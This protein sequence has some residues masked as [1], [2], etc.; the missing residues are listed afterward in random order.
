MKTRSLTLLMFIVITTLMLYGCSFFRGTG[1]VTTD[2]NSICSNYS[3]SDKS[4]LPVALIHDMINGYRGNQLQ[5][6][7]NGR[8]LIDSRSI[9]FD[10]E[11]LKTFIYHIENTTVTTDKSKSANDLG[12]RIY[13]SRYPDKE[14]FGWDKKEYNGILSRFGNTPETSKYDKLHTLVMV[15]TRKEGKLNVDFNPLDPETYNKSLKSP[16]LIRYSRN[17]QLPVSSNTY[18]TALVLGGPTN[19]NAQNHGSLIPPRDPGLGEE[20]FGQ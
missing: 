2:N 1:S 12:I 20:G 4:E 9:W 6:I 11:T 5:Y 10:L 7:Q 19:T 16:E 14:N 15:P 18:P 3:N 17:Y 13:Y 8:S